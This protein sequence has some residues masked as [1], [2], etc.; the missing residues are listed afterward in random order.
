[1]V[2]VAKPRRLLLPLISVLAAPSLAAALKPPTSLR[3]LPPGARCPLARIP[4]VWAS[5][6]VAKQGQL[7]CAKRAS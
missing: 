6:A 5:K 4:P 7:S 3:L 1:M 2:P